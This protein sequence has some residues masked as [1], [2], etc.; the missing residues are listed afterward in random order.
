[1]CY[2]SGWKSIFSRVFASELVVG[3]FRAAGFRQA[4]KSPATVTGS[5]G[6]A[7][8]WRYFFEGGIISP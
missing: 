1:M 6:C 2:G 4:E 7:A 3:F 8:V 5:E